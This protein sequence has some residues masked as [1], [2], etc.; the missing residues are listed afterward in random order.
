MQKSGLQPCLVSSARDNAGHSRDNSSSAWDRTT[1]PFMASFYCPTDFFTEN[2]SPFLLWDL[3]ATTSFIALPNGVQCQASHS[4]LTSGSFLRSTEVN[5]R[6]VNGFPM[7]TSAPIK[8]QSI[9]GRQ[10]INS[11]LPFMD[12]PPLPPSLPPDHLWFL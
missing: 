11:D 12:C 10:Q 4:S 2:V 5:Q 7:P 1:I 3:L 9:R 6:P 8:R